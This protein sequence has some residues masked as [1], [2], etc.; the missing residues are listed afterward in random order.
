MVIIKKS[1]NNKCWTGCGETATFLHCWWE[2]K[3]MQPLWRT[4]W[5]FLEKLGINLPFD[6]TIPPLGINPE[7]TI[8]EKDACTLMFTAA[9]FTIARTGKQPRCPS[10]D[11]WIKELWYIHTVE[12]YS[13]I[14]RKPSESVLMRWIKIESIIQG[15]VSQK[16]KKSILMHIYGI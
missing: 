16:E 4:I 15:K 12:Y 1:R 10:T 3:L 5:R 13:A 8:T 11:E 6:P 14:E 7:E 2:C 9:L